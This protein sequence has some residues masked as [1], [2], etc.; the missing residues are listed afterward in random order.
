LAAVN[1]KIFVI[2][3]QRVFDDVQGDRGAT[4]SDF[5]EVCLFGIVE[6]VLLIVRSV[7]LDFRRKLV[8]H[9]G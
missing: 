1:A 3:L 6:V 2:Y 9:D 5:G 7:V 8:R 4:T